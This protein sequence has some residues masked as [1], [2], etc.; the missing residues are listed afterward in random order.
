MNSEIIYIKSNDCVEVRNAIRDYLLSKGY[1]EI[2]GQ[3]L[4]AASLPMNFQ[5]KNRRYFYLVKFTEWIGVF[6]NGVRADEEL[7][8]CIS[9]SL[10]KEVI[11][12]ALHE[13]INAWGR[14]KF[15]NS[16]SEKKLFPEQAFTQS[17]FNEEYLGDA[18]EEAINFCDQNHLPT[19]FINYS[20]IAGQLLEILINLEIFHIS[21]YRSDKAM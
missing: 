9:I 5:N 20:Q 2:G 8:A 15:Y 1:V 14:I 17:I 21:F 11:W 4:K 7:A 6:E 10:A 19:I 18:T 3:P 13:S 12:I 16:N